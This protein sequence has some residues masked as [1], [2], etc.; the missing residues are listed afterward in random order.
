MDHAV[1]IIQTGVEPRTGYRAFY[2]GKTSCLAVRLYEHN[3]NR[4]AK[5][6]R[7]DCHLSGKRLTA[8]LTTA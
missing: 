3:N 6:R 4:D 8:A 1:Y 7:S 5:S 2:T